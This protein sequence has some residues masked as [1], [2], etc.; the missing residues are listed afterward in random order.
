LRASTLS[1]ITSVELRLLILFAVNWIRK[2]RGK[3][4]AAGAVFV[5]VALYFISTTVHPQGTG[6]LSGPLKVRMFKSETHLLGFYPV[7]LVERWI[8]NGSLTMASY[9]FNVDFKDEKYDHSWL[10]GDGKYDRIWY[11]PH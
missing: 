5:Y 2:H 1:G 7:Y 3:V 4:I 11:D 8:R 9:Y 10:Y 6:G